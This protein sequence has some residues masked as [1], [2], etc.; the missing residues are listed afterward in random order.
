MVSTGPYKF[1]TNDLGKSFTLVRN[2]NWDPATDP[3]RKALPDRIEVTLNVNADDI[4]NRLHRPVTWTSTSRARACSRPRRAKIL[5]DPTLKANT[6]N[7]CVARLLV[8]RDQ[9]RRWR[10]WTTSTAARRS[11][12]AADQTGYQ[13]AYGG[14]AGGDIATNLLPPVIPGCAEVRPLPDAGQHTATSTRP[15]TAL[16]RAASPTASRPTSPTA[17]SGRRRRRPPRRCSSRWRGS[18]SSSTLKPYPL[19]DYFKLYAGKPDFAKANG[20]GLMVNGWG[21]DWPDGY[22]FL[23]QIVDSRVIR[24]TGGNTNLSVSGPR[25]RR[26]ARQGAAR[27]PTPPR[28]SRSGSTIDKKVMDDAVILPGIWAK[29]L[30]L[31][32]EEPDQRVRHRRRSS[33]YDYVALGVQVAHPSDHS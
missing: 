13:R 27:R 33:M 31:P 18:A 7:P 19:G 12:Y 28:A 10:R 15:R 22:G 32:A 30:L 2:P 25:G 17:P 24:A 16:Q 1:E 21:A 8:H 9:R 4:D 14:A 26:A 5:A 29:G 3:N 6:D 23:A 11:L 20:L